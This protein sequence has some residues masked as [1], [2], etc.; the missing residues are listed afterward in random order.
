MT[1]LKTLLAGYFDYAGLY[2]PASHSM[3]SAANNYLDYSHSK[4]ASLL[5]RFIIDLNRLDEVRS[6]VCEE[7]LKQFKLSVI[8]SDISALDAISKEI[9]KGTPIETL[10]FKAS[11]PET[12]EQIAT[13][14]PH[15]IT[16]YFEIPFEF[17]AMN[18][19]SDMGVRA[20][21]RMG[22]VVAGAF[23][24]VSAVVRMLKVLASLRIPFKATAGLHHPFRS[25]QPLTYE[26]QSS[27]ATMHG[28]LNLCCA[29]AVLHFGGEESDAEM[30]L[31]D[32]DRS[33]WQVDGGSLRW[34][35]LRWTE[36]HLSALRREF[37]MG[38]GS[39]SFEEPIQDLEALG[40]L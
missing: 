29:A 2:P 1:A 31:Q 11:D 30:V 5:G 24:P 33:A 13:G 35:H 39:C 34:R 8:A 12:I 20:K 23:P 19:I 9:E 14:V 32:E 38:V 26:P 22:G 3:R 4:H 25:S 18:V 40:W 28:F 17:N 10:E 6:I 16:T 37:F 15:S 7:D 21:V 27:Q 36:E